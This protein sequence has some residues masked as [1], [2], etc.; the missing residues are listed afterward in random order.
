MVELNVV[1]KLKVLPEGVDVDL[2][3]I[4]EK[5]GEIV[6]DY[7]KIHSL[8]IK[9]VA[10]GLNCIEANLLLSDSEGGLEEIEQKVS[11]LAGVSDVNVL[12]VNRL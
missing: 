8:E 12:D 7:G 11:D 4:Q 3:A 9:P 5:L 2:E 10:F 1:A 6:S